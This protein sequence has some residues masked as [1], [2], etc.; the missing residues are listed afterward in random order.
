[1][2][3]RHTVIEPDRLAEHLGRKVQPAGV[4]RE[5]AQQV[6]GIAVVRA[7]RETTLHQ[8]F[9]AGVVPVLEKLCGGPER[10][11]RTLHMHPL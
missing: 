4:S 2:I 11:L 6:Q 10:I 1:V 7:F 5:H 3:C 9:G 8:L